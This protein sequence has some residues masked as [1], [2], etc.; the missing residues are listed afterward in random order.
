MCCDTDNPRTRKERE[1]ALLELL[2]DQPGDHITA[3]AVSPAQA[4]HNRRLAYLALESDLQ[5]NQRF[6][7]MRLVVLNGRQE[8]KEVMCGR[9]GEELKVVRLVLVVTGDVQRHHALQEDLRRR[10]VAEQRVAGDV[11]Q[12]AL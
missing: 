7:E 11:E 10:V 8:D 9:I 3:R 2:G 5:D 12:L 6:G 1:L 4:F